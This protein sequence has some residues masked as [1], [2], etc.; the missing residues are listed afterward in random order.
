MH[1]L[2]AGDECI[3]WYGMRGQHSASMVYFEFYIANVV[4]QPMQYF[5]GPDGY[6]RFDIAV[7]RKK[8]P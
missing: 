7:T 6:V 3:V 4:L 1:N 8:T 5:L 2:M